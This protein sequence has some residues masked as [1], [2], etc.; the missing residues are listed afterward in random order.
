GISN[1]G[2]TFVLSLPKLKSS[3]LVLVFSTFEAEKHIVSVTSSLQPSSF[4]V[5][6]STETTRPGVLRLDPD[7]LNFYERTTVGA[8]EV[9]SGF[10]RLTCFV[11]SGSFNFSTNVYIYQNETYQ[12]LYSLGGFMALPIES[13]GTEYHI[14]TL[15]SYSFLLIIANVNTTVHVS[16][17]ANVLGQ[18][19]QS[20]SRNNCQTSS[21]RLKRY[22]TL[23]L[24]E[25]TETTSNNTMSYTGS[26]VKGDN[27]IGAL[28]GNCVSDQDEL[29][30]TTKENIMDIS[31]DMLLPIYMYGQEF[32]TI[33]VPWQVSPSEERLV[34]VTSQNQTYVYVTF[35]EAS[36]QR[37]QL[38]QAH[39]IHYI[40]VHMNNSIRNGLI[41]SD[42]PI[43][44]MYFTSRCKEGPHLSSG[45][46]MGMLLP[47]HLFYNMYTL[48]FNWDT[49]IYHFVVIVML[50]EKDFY[51]LT[52][53]GMPGQLKIL[54]TSK[55]IGRKEAATFYTKLEEVNETSITSSANFGCY[56]Y[57]VSSLGSYFHAAGFL[58]DKD[59]TLDC[60]ASSPQD[61]DCVDNDC[62][63]TK[64]EEVPNKIDDD[65]DGLVDEDTFFVRSHIR[66]SPVANQTATMNRNKGTLAAGKTSPKPEEVPAVRAGTPS[67]WYVVMLIMFIAMGLAALTSMFIGKPPSVTPMT[68]LPRKDVEYMIPE[69]VLLDETFIMA[70]RKRSGTSV[71]EKD[72]YIHYV[73]MQP[74][75]PEAKT[76]GKAK[77]Q[78]VLTT[79]GLS[80]ETS[81]ASGNKSSEI[82]S[83]HSER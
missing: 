73:K 27:P 30:C 22:Q 60:K 41:L 10:Y 2:R 40:D 59:K 3:S 35:A 78:S 69:V 37:Y 75:R 72:H 54:G 77:L 32:F 39:Q 51:N 26:V 9:N 63:G 6:V 25:C 45:Q 57:G 80:L 52:W 67:F 18:T 48:S 68:R 62:D 46:S 47:V 43:N 81:A 7:R 12:R 71:D 33:F 65:G 70:R 66:F 82:I 42:K 31:I 76:K 14:F 55:V 15:A 79:V 24:M 29:S 16:L 58:Y 34:V 64:D 20:I 83:Q 56:Y 17:C 61:G 4:D 28:S 50:Q 74:K 23:A 11:A 8:R 19:S 49:G 13:W 36:R 1:M 44:V 38:T 5:K 21:H 53:Y